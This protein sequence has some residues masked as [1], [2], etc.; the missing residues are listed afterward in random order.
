MIVHA[1]LWVWQRRLVNARVA[2]E[3]VN[4]FRH[5]KLV[6]IVAK[7][8]DRV[9]RVEFAVHWCKVLHIETINVGDN[10]HLIQAIQGT[11]EKP[12]GKPHKGVRMNRLQTSRD[13]AMPMD[14][15]K[16]TLALLQSHDNPPFAAAPAQFCDPNRTML[17]STPQALP[18]RGASV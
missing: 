14:I 12:R 3:S 6:E 18:V 17:P 13:E 9:K 8:S 5:A 16:L 11:N 10:F 15:R 7:L 4:W 1:P 2:N